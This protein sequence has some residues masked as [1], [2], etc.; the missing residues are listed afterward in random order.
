MAPE[1]Q[2]VNATDNIEFYCEAETDVVEAAYLTVGW[3]R[4][5]ERIDYTNEP[6]IQKN[7]RTDM[8]TIMRVRVSDSGEYQCVASNGIDKDTS[9]AQLKVRGGCPEELVNLNITGTI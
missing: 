3:H 7:L 4:N 1:N 9:T 8:L 6:R 2:T 5:G